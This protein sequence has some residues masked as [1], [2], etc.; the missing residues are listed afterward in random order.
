MGNEKA[1]EQHQRKPREASSGA[2]STSNMTTV[3]GVMQL[4]GD[5]CRVDLLGPLPWD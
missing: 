2:L 4:K 3:D 1:P 5:R